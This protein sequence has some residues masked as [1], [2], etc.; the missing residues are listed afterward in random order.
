MDLDLGQERALLKRMTVGQL[1]LRY[2]E[3][4]GEPTG[5]RHKL[6]LERRIA[7]RLQALA[8]GDLSQRA[9]Q[10]ASKLANDADL[11]FTPPRVRTARAPQPTAITAPVPA[12]ADRRLPPPGTTLTR[13]YK[14]QILEVHV[15]EQGLA[16]EGQVFASLSAVAKSITGSHCN[17][18][19]FFRLGRPE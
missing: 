11:R 19:H 12:V 10:R 18:F 9:R 15:L 7:W 4:F 13:T 5:A 8:E 1:R 2:A 3:L 6:W 14:G 17:G 16:Y